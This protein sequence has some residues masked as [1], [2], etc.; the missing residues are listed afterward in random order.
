MLSIRRSSSSTSTSAGAALPSSPEQQQQPQQDHR[1]LIINGQDA[2]LGRYPYFTTLDRYCAGALIAPDI[3]L[4]AGHCK[5]SILDSVK[6]HIGTYYFKDVRDRDDDDGFGSG[7]DD[8][9]DYNDS[10]KHKHNKHKKHDDD[11]DEDD[12]DV[13]SSSPS[14]TRSNLPEYEEYAIVDVIRHPRFKPLGGDEFVHDFTVLKLKDASSIP[15]VSLNRDPMLPVDGQTVTAMGLGF[16]HPEDDARPDVLQEVDLNYLPNDQCELAED[17][18]ESFEGRIHSTHMCTFVQPDNTKD[19]CAFDSG[20]PIIMQQ[21]IQVETETVVVT[22]HQRW[23]FLPP[24]QEEVLVTTTTTKSEDVLVALVSWGVGCADPVFPG[25]NARVSA[26]SD[27]IDEQVCRL[28]LHPPKEF[29]CA[30][31]QPLPPVPPVEIPD[32]ELPAPHSRRH[33]LPAFPTGENVQDETTF[34]LCFLLFVFSC[35]GGTAVVLRWMRRTSSDHQNQKGKHSPIFDKE[36]DTQSLSSSSG[37]SA[38]LRSQESDNE[39]D[40]YQSMEISGSSSP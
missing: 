36:Y 20:G 4:T 12:D 7:D 18:D 17:S 8:D 28:S 24:V 14:R 27:W 16:I 5:P 21:E 37:E 2:S 39:N 13:S 31:K 1:S 34:I 22:E 6:L 25:V 19:A 33:R 10:H 38:S 32:H 15:Y 26:V 9:D 23:F 35:L 29:G 3:V 30:P 11:D 40:Y